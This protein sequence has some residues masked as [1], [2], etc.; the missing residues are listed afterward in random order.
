MA[1]S[2][3]YHSL[4]NYRSYEYQSR[5]KVMVKSCVMRICLLPSALTLYNLQR[6]GLNIPF[7]L[8]KLYRTGISFHASTG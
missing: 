3:A 2:N 6:H 4:K 8:W 7:E 5:I 1:L